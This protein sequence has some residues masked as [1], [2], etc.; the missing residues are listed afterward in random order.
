MVPTLTDIRG[1]ELYLPGESDRTMRQRSAPEQ[2]DMT[3][4]IFFVNRRT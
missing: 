1:L 3:T 2:A 4:S